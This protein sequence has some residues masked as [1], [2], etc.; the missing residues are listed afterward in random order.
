MS[1][2][3]WI[4]PRHQP[5]EVLRT[6]IAKLYLESGSVEIQHFRTVIEQVITGKH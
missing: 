5:C 1:L 4:I 6:A 2:G 3:C